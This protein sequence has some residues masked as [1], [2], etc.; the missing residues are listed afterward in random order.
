MVEIKAMSVPMMNIR[1]RP[2]ISEKEDQNNGPS[3]NPKAGIATVQFTC[4]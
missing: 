1:R 2:Y 4:A 3:A